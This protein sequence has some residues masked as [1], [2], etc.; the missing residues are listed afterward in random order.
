MKPGPET[1]Y[2]LLEYEFPNF[3]KFFIPFRK[4]DDEAKLSEKFENPI[5]IIGYACTVQEAQS[6]LFGRVYADNF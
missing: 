5:K 3:G 4:E 1:K 2:A 6:A